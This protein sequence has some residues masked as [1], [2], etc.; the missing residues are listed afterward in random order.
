[1]TLS[2]LITNNDLMAKFVN[3]IIQKMYPKTEIWLKFARKRN[4]PKT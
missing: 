3:L 1:M 4:C 2:K